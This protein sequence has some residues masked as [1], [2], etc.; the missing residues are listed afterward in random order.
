MILGKDDAVRMREATAVIIDDNK[1]SEE[2]T[3][4]FELL[5]DLV[6]NIDNANSIPHHRSCAHIN[7]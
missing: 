3:A 5:Q 7:A 6:E 1:P 2:R 4:A